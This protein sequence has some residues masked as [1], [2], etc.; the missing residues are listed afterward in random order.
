MTFR[1]L[2][3][4]VS[5]VAA[6]AGQAT[7][8]YRP[9]LTETFWAN[10][11][12]DNKAEVAQGLKEA[13]ALHGII[14]GDLQSVEIAAGAKITKIDVYGDTRIQGVQFTYRADNGRELQT[15]VLGGRFGKLASH[16]I[17]DQDAFLGLILAWDEK[18]MRTV[19][20]MTVEN[21]AGLTDVEQFD[22]AV[23][24]TMLGA[25]P[26]TYDQED[27]TQLILLPGQEL[28]GLVACRAPFGGGIAALTV[29]QGGR[30]DPELADWKCGNA[31]VG[32]DLWGGPG[33]DSLAEMPYYLNLSGPWTQKDTGFDL[34]RTGDPI[35]DGTNGSRLGTYDVPKY[36]RVE[37]ADEGKFLRLLGSD[38]DELVLPRVDESGA[39]VTYAQ[40]L[41]TAR[42]STRGF[43]P[44][45][46]VT[47]PDAPHLPH[48][49]TYVRSKLKR[50]KARTVV[51]KVFF[52][53][54][55][56]PSETWRGL[57]EQ[58]AVLFGFS[59][60]LA[61][62]DGPM[63]NLED[64]DR[65]LKDDFPIF[66]E[67]DNYSH[68]LDTFI[69][70]SVPD[71]LVVQNRGA[72][73][74]FEYT[75]TAITSSSEM[76]RTVSTNF[77]LSG[78][79]KGASLGVTYSNSQTSGMRQSSNTM[80]AMGNARILQYSVVLDRGSAQLSPEFKADLTDMI[81]GLRTGYDI[82]AKYGTHY[83]N[84]IT[85]GGAA[86]ATK[87]FSQTEYA[88]WRSEN[89]SASVSGG[90]KGV[91]GNAGAS[92]QESSRQNSLVSFSRSD[93][94]SV[95]GTGG[96][97]IE[98]FTPGERPV[99]V[100]YDLR[101]ISE[102]ARP[103][104]LPELP[105]G[106]WQSFERAQKD[107]DQAIAYRFDQVPLEQINVTPQ[108]IYKVT[109]QGITCD[110][111]G[112]E[113][114][115]EIELS[116]DIRVSISQPDQSSEEFSVWSSSDEETVDCDGIPFAQS[117][118]TMGVFAPEDKL[119]ELQL[120]YNYALEEHDTP[121]FDANETTSSGNTYLI[122][123]LLGAGQIAASAEYQGKSSFGGARG[124]PRIIVNYT[125]ERI[126]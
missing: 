30:I 29:V 54:N 26:S 103:F 31:P 96:T 43:E 44:V 60:N 79:A 80:M 119:G 84:A 16:D 123:P 23:R 77:G 100:L 56:R 2:A 45:L 13:S 73:S 47:A 111:K 42:F 118:R 7:A 20:V 39:E 19:G 62:Y 104:Y 49:G 115:N 71:G 101:P 98:G 3:S 37:F 38:H 36:V 51:D 68:Y 99:P 24:Q 64:P 9:E 125:V 48:I 85:Y 59:W 78:G 120:W 41:F 18:Q 67:P 12:D 110:A 83:A 66:A 35:L 1:T 109:F 21:A 102:L 55:E 117:G 72:K 34:R 58:S 69:S 70:K 93:F 112:D 88:T 76:Q 114:D 32:D 91:S 89:E 65:G 87:T 46:S 90:A 6:I 25:D 63:M 82:V 5:F 52:P 33:Y 107:L 116:G 17:A 50:P 53:E 126:E 61:G 10:L 15:D 14:S 108:A 40:G 74:L 22:A 94:R 121:P 113:G 122:Q 27:Y 75:E 86:V 28:R 57:F 11:D 8:Q 105:R 106:M 97:T 95:G 92:E 4:V 124:M 81:M